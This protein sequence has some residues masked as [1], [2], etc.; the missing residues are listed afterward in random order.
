MIKVNGSL[1][2]KSK[3]LQNGRLAMDKYKR[4]E[5]EKSAW[6]HLHPNATPEAVERAFRAIADRLGV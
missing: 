1:F 2:C 5:S 3:V 6:L 4:Y